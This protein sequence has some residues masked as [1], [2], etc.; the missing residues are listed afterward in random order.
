V[1]R[2]LGSLMFHFSVYYIIQFASLLI[3]IVLVSLVL[4]CQQSRTKRLM[5]LFLAAGAGVCMAGLLANLQIPYEQLIIWQTLV[6]LFTTWSIVTYVHFIPASYGHDT[7]K[8]AQLGYAWLVLAA[9]YLIAINLAQGLVYINNEVMSRYLVAAIDVLAYVNILVIALVGLFLFNRLQE[10]VLPE[11]RSR[12]SFL[13]FGLGTLMAAI[14]ISIVYRNTSYSFYQIGYTIN[15]V[16]ITY[17]LI[18]YRILDIRVYMKRWIVYTGLTI[19]ITLGFLMLLLGLSNA[20]RLLPANSGIPATIVMVMLFAIFFNWMKSILDKVSDKL[21]YGK[22]KIHRQL[23]LNFAN[24]MRGFLT[25]KEI[26]NAFIGPL[27][28][29]VQARQVGM[30]LPMKRGYVT[31]YVVKLDESDEVF[32]LV[33]QHQSTLKGW[34]ADRG[35][36][37]F[38]QNLEK[39]PRFAWISEID[40]QAL[41]TAHAEVLCPITGNG[42]LFGIL[43]LSEKYPQGHYSRDDIELISA[44]ARESAVAFENAQIHARARDKSGTDDLTGLSNHRYFQES[45]TKAVEDSAVSGA[46]FALL[47]IDLDLFETYNDIYGYSLGDELLVDLGKLIWNTIRDTDTGARYGGDEFAC[48]LHQTDVIGAQKVAERIRHKMEKYSEQKGITVTCSIGVAGWRIDGVTKEKI[49]EAADRALL[50]AKRSGGNRTTLASNMDKAELIKP[51]M[52]RNTRGSQA[53][54]NI[55][56]ALAAT[57]DARDHYTYGHSKAV[58]RYAVEIA[59]EIGYS[60]EKVQTIR[61]AGLLHDIGKLNLPDSILTKRDPL[62]DA[63]WDMI[64]YHP[65]LGT[66]ILKYIP[67]LRECMDAVLYHHERYDGN[68]YPSGLRGEE[69]PKDAR[70]MAIADSY[71]AMISERGYKKRKLTKKEAIEE[72]EACSGTQFDPE[73]VKIFIEI[74]KKSITPEIEPEDIFEINHPGGVKKPGR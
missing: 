3:Y 29:A 69:I 74:R 38:R 27:A 51:E 60:P 35:Q 8:I 33:L 53:M 54:E 52:T 66:R 11:E 39:D 13:L 28:G 6:P 71:D 36:P 44:L 2:L 12:A 41:Q 42:Q 24:K 40:R 20:L 49:I 22:R 64:R 9:T 72:L 25:T 16:L 19:S 47:F 56:F 31:K 30:L 23:L 43:M 10:A 68:G 57:V 70:I 15:A 18:R 46:D 61:S 4:Y 26:A 34:I 63:E 45:L 32:S 62:T 17:A 37:V 14:A 59:R 67:G 1:F 50:H 73:L 58:S 55:V 48:L 7:A 21:F 5:V 65:E